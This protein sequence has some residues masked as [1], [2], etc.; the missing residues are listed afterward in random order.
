MGEEKDE[1]HQ[2]SLSCNDSSLHLNPVIQ[3][4]QITDNCGLSVYFMIEP[5]ALKIILS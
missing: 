2:D 4:C 3:L 5:V 1:F